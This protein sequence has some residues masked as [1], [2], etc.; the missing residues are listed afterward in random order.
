MIDD[1]PYKIRLGTDTNNCK[2]VDIQDIVEISFDRDN[3]EVNASIKNPSDHTKYL[4]NQGR[5][6]IYLTRM[7]IGETDH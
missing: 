1:Q 5:L 7:L 2:L 3:Q 6:G 4:F